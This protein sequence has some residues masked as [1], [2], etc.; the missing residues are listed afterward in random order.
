MY[1]VINLIQNIIDVHNTCWCVFVYIYI[2][3]RALSLY[4][5]SFLQIKRTLAGIL[6]QVEKVMISTATE[7]TSDAYPPTA[8]FFTQICSIFY[9]LV[10]VIFTHCVGYFSTTKR[11]SPCKCKKECGFLTIIHKGKETR[12]VWK[13]RKPKV[14]AVEK[15]KSLPFSYKTVELQDI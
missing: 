13:R 15:G 5:W 4:A 1:S 11:A 8:I 10:K 3:L 2:I 9:S 7:Q 12:L 6:V 14:T